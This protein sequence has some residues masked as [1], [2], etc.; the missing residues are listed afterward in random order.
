MVGIKLLTL[1]NFFV[2]S[3]GHLGGTRNKLDTSGLTTCRGPEVQLQFN[4]GSPYMVS[5]RFYQRLSD[6]P[7]LFLLSSFVSTHRLLD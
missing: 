2:A 7:N 6:G 5:M 1:N 3:T 4:S